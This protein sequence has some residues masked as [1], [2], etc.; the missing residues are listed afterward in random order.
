MNPHSQDGIVLFLSA[1]E[2][3]RLFLTIHR[4][5]FIA[6]LMA[7]GGLPIPFEKGSSHPATMMMRCWP[8][9]NYI[10][11][12]NILLNLNYN[13]FDICPLLFCSTLT[14]KWWVSSPLF[15]PRTKERFAMEYE[16][17][18]AHHLQHIKLPFQKAAS[19]SERG[20]SSYCS[21][22][23]PLRCCIILCNFGEFVFLKES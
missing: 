9:Q 2:H 7:L 17:W 18:Q 21:S 15:C 16:V 10:S 23:S 13:F 8:G 4:I 20:G 12:S 6:I 14:N 1:A 19:N 22:S 11:K 5:P 3:Q